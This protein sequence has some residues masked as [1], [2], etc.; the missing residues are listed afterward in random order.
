MVLIYMPEGGHSGGD[1]LR[2]RHPLLPTTPLLA[3][4][5]AGTGSPGAY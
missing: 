5:G 4:A 1:S 3:A 2:R